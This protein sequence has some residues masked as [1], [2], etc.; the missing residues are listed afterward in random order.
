[1][2]RRA[3]GLVLAL[4]LLVVV[5]GGVWWLVRG[6]RA[7]I[8]GAEG[9]P[10]AGTGKRIEIEAILYYPGPQGLLRAE[11]R[12]LATTDD[13]AYQ[14][15]S[16]VR[17]FLT[18]PENKTLARS[19][20]PEVRVGAVIVGPDRIAYVDLRAQERPE[21]PAA[22]SMEEQQMVYGVVNSVVESVPAVRAVALLWNGSQRPTF[23]GHLDTGR[24]LGPDRTLVA[25]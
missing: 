12:R 22:G 16:V 15:W 24:P 17:A 25:R 4:A 7:G 1:M 13:P 8:E 11:R 3:A 23:C 9:P 21:P 20:P 10:P 14:V 6:R 19:F 18:G 5:G 2:S